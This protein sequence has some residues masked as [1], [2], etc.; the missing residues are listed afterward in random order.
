MSLFPN[1][2][3]NGSDISDIDFM[4]LTEIFDTQF[5][6]ASCSEAVIVSQ[7]GADEESEF[8]LSMHSL[9]M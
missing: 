6:N 5:M 2:L 9:H 8:T 3:S 7:S 1:T 4:N